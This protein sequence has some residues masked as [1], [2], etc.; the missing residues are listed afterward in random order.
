M[1]RWNPLFLVVP[2]FLVA[3]L[4]PALVTPNR[5]MAAGA[6]SQTNFK[7]KAAVYYRSSAAYFVVNF[8]CKPSGTTSTLSGNWTWETSSEASYSGTLAFTGCQL[9]QNTDGSWSSTMDGIT[10]SP[11]GSIN[12]ATLNLAFSNITR[13]KTYVSNTTTYS[14]P[15]N[16]SGC[17][18]N[19]GTPP[20]PCMVIQTFGLGAAVGADNDDFNSNPTPLPDPV[21]YGTLNLTLPKG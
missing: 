18:D 9:M 6:A 2:L 1:R 17:V 21:P 20:P 8:T 10:L 14:T 13:T 15:S 7:G 16:T 19:P 11:Q 12:T 4:A 3:L 5:A